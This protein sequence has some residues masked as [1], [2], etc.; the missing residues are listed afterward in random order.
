MY[1]Y[2]TIR[3]EIKSGPICFIYKINSKNEL[4]TSFNLKLF[5]ILKLQNN[6]NVESRNCFREKMLR[7]N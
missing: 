7:T 6:S 2:N 3:D 1:N 4:C 5:A